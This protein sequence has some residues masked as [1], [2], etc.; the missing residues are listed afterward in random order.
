[1][2]DTS[3]YIQQGRTTVPRQRLAATG[4]TYTT[5]SVST[6]PAPRPAPRRS[7]K[8][9]PNLYPKRFRFSRS[10]TALLSSIAHCLLNE[11]LPPSTPPPIPP[12]C[13]YSPKRLEAPL[14]GART[15]ICLEKVCVVNGQ[16]TTASNKEYPPPPPTPPRLAP[17]RNV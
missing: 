1:M 3:V 2:R 16:L 7:Q 10:V 6:L 13:P 12:P 8:W 4:L 14:R 9:S 15:V 5:R 17:R 11:V